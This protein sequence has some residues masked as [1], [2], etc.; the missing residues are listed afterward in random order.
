MKSIAGRIIHNLSKQPTKLFL[1][2]GIGALLTIFYLFGILQKFNAYIGM[3]V[4]TLNVLG[5]IA[6]F[7]F[8]YSIFCFLFIRKNPAPFIRI[9]SLSNLLYCLLTLVL[10][11]YNYTT[12][13]TLG[14]TYFLLEITIIC[15]LA[16]IE[17]GL[18]DLIMKKKP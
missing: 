10:V 17:Y 7:F 18:A 3:P 1:I 5:I 4:F 2:D 16:Y 13:T 8:A 15:V 12:L 6:S 11:I 14:I 9:I